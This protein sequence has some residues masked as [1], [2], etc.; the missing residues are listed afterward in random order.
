[1]L[2]HRAE[3]SARWGGPVLD[4]HL[5]PGRQADQEIQHIEGSG[6]DRA[7]LLPGG[8]LEQ[9]AKDAQAAHPKRFLRF[10]N[11]DVRQPEAIRHLA[12]AVKGGA[13]GFGELKYP[14]ALDGPE[15]RRV[16]ELAGDLG[17]PVLIHFEEGN[18]NTG[19]RSFPALLKQYR[20]TTFLAHANSFWAHLSAKVDDRE[21]Y[22]AGRIERGGISDRVLGDFENVF[23]D[24]SANSGRNALSR[25]PEFSA[26]FLRRHKKKLLFGSDCPCRDGKGS[27]QVSEQPL[28]KGRCVAVETLTALGKLAPTDVVRQ[29]VWG[30]GKQLFRL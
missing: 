23:G 25:D 11:A 21:A 1:M 9:K 22:P 27:G 14:V 2:A 16:Y 18:W 20:K 3:G 26:D 28:I 15:M 19:I 29:I 13:I 4:I 7:I 8:G 10:A 24:L 5:H 12:E 17:V 30:N 6:V